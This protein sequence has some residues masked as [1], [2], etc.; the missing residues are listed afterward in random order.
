MVPVPLFTR[1]A[2]NRKRVY[3]KK[4]S[5]T[6]KSRKI[7]YE[8]HD[9]ASVILCIGSNHNHEKFLCN[10]FLRITLQSLIFGIQEKNKSFKTFDRSVTKDKTLISLLFY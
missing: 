9:K 6:S 5:C 3:L 2:V 4:K 8:M 7:L 10:I 1:L